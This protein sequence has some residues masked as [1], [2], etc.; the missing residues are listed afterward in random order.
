MKR[1]KRSLL[2]RGAI[3]G[4]VLALFLAAIYIAWEFVAVFV[5][6]VFLY[7]AVRPIHDGLTVFGL[8]RKVRAALAILMFGL[9]FVIL[10][11]YAITIVAIEIQSF[12]ETYDSQ[13]ALLND[14]IANVN[15]D[16]FTQ[17]EFQ[18]II[19]EVQ[20]ETP[21]AEGLLSVTSLV[22]RLSSA[23]VKLIVLLVLTY[24]MLVD[25]PRL[26]SWVVN[27]L[28][29]GGVLAEYTRMADREL[30]ST[31]FGNIVNVFATGVIGVVVFTS[32]N[33]YGPAALQI[34]FPGLLGALAGIGSLIPV[35]GIKLVY[36]PVVGWLA[37]HAWMAGNADLLGPVLMLLIVSAIFI[38]FI[39]DMFIRALVSG[40]ATHTGVLVAAYI[41]GPTVLGFYGLFLAP[42]MLVLII[43]AG[44]ILVPYV[45]HGE[46]PPER[47]ATFD[48]YTSD[49]QDHAEA[50]RWEVVSERFWKELERVVDTVNRIR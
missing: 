27:N 7:Y 33:F 19:R 32:Y 22:S 43:C 4:V 37:A 9:P 31:L 21:I 5:L 40:D 47:Q 28:D 35:I 36:G 20:S 45:I 2:H 30:S 25:G 12:V 44:H 6:A 24:S 11:A 18:E 26:K 1:A 34:P 29:H 14:L 23:F 13:Q 3:G 15:L 8:P 41:I 46:K 10:T 16:G 48:E 39:P 17:Q 38:D 50:R 42:I 49:K